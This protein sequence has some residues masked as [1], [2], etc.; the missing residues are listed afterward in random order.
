MEQG[1]GHGRISSKLGILIVLGL[2]KRKKNSSR[3]ILALPQTYLLHDHFSVP[4][5]P[6]GECCSGLP[7]A[8]SYCLPEAVL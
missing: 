8:S 4:I 7:A 3:P 2:K 6:R 1:L 5:N